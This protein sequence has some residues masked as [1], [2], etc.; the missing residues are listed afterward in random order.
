MFAAAC[1]SAPSTNA[2]T[3]CELPGDIDCARAMGKTD[4]WNST[5]SPTRFAQMLEYRVDK[6]PGE[7]KAKNEVWADTYWPTAEGSTNAR[8]QGEETLSPLEKYD[9]AF[10]NW[11]PTTPSQYETSVPS[12]CGENAKTEY[13]SYQSWLGP[14]AR[15]QS[16]AQNRPAMFN[17]INDDAS[18]DQQIDECREIVEGWWGLCHAWAPA[19]ILEPEPLHAV[20]LNG[21]RFEVGD[22]KAL[23]ITAYDDTKAIMLGGRCNAKEVKHDDTG[24]VIASECRDTNAGAWHVVVA[25][26]LGK[27]QQGF[28]EDRTAGAQVWNQP[29]VGYHITKQEEISVEDANRLLQ[30][31][32]ADAGVAVDGGFGARQAYAY[33]ARA[34]RFVEIEMTTDYLVEGAASRYPLGSNGYI[35]HDHYHY[36]LE[37]NPDGKIIGGEWIGYSRNT[38]PDF[39]WLPIEASAKTGYSRSNPHVNFAQIQTLIRLSREQS[40]AGAPTTDAGPG[41]APDAGVSTLID[42]GRASVDAGIPPSPDSGA[43]TWRDAG[44]V[45]VTNDA[46]LVT[47]DAGFVTNDVELVIDPEQ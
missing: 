5:N 24:R 3:A 44:T 17:G 47:H 9:K 21:Q 22:I 43:P 10:N 28:V 19:A 45:T 14:A 1:T 34:T 11:K 46:G 35:R 20:E 26:L 6:L 37:L 36:I 4:E 41:A 13:G 25:N 39:L 32:A 7:G 30:V 27:N 16:N 33:N 2:A 8:W 29:L 40:D 38:H 23:I 31:P 12:D 15:W 18:E 42:A